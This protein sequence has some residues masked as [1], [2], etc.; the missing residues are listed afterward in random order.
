M[1]DP[2]PHFQELIEQVLAPRPGKSSSMR[3][4]ELLLRWIQQHHGAQRGLLVS[5][6]EVGEYK[7]WCSR[8]AEGR[9]VPVA[10]TTVSHHAFELGC[11]GKSPVLFKDAHL[12]RR[13]RS[14]SE[15]EGV[16]RARWILVIPLGKPA[17]RTAVYLDSRFGDGPE[18]QQSGSKQQMVLSLIDLILERERSD[19]RAETPEFTSVADPP[20]SEEPAVVAKNP[21][22]PLEPRIVSQIGNFISHSSVLSKPIEEL[23]KIALTR[24]SVLIEGESGTGKD[25]LARAIHQASGGGEFMVLHCGTLNESLIEV[26]L[27]GNEK[28]AFTDADQQRPGLLDRASGGTLLL[29]AIDEASP[30][31]QAALLR[32][33]D[34]GT[35]RRVAGT[36]ELVAD[37]RFLACS[38]SDQGTGRIRQELRYRLAGL[39]VHLPPLRNRPLDSLLIIDQ[40]LTEEMVTPPLL[41]ADAQALLLSHHWPGNGWDAV[42][43]ARRIGASGLSSID[44]ASMQELLGGSILNSGEYSTGVKDV[45]GRAEREVIMRALEVAGGNKSEACQALGISRRT[46]YR[47]MK[48]HGIPLKDPDE[49]AS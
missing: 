40:H 19:S 6:V 41:E 30:A 11:A 20:M 17:Q 37:L 43:L 15:K 5:A 34:S 36:E 10:A 42:H 29:D 27:F 28:G 3:G 26:E 2:D 38:S 9:K 49:G 16:Q 39:E 33:I 12:D 1:T 25:L 32:V 14:P 22:A 44:G 8:G 46:L 48:K 13:L 7:V 21:V 31:L 45:L 23:K 4:V 47:R 18:N 24:I 35:Y